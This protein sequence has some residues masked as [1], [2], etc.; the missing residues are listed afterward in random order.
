MGNVGCVPPDLITTSQSQSDVFR[1]CDDSG[2]F[3]SFD[4]GTRRWRDEETVFPF[5]ATFCGPVEGNIP[6]RNSFLIVGGHG[7]DNSK[8]IYWVRALAS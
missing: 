2:S 4:L 6:F 3:M 8:N 1:K 5:T 7:V